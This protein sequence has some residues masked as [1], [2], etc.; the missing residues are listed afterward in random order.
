M[1]QRISES[2]GGDRV[3]KK[4][5]MV[6]KYIYLVFLKR[7]GEKVIGPLTR[8]ARSHTNELERKQGIIDTKRDRI[9]YT[10]SRDFRPKSFT[11]FVLNPVERLVDI[12]I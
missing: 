9:S 6:D 4:I 8:I 7:A 12:Y 11:S 3:S 5:E 10:L 1:G 2:G